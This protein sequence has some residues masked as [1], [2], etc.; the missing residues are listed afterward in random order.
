VK[1][2]MRI[3]KI[4]I[5]LMLL[6]AL[7]A[8]SFNVSAYNGTLIVNDGTS[9]VISDVDEN[10]SL[11]NV[12]IKE[13]KC[14]QTGQMVEISL[15]LEDG[16]KFEDSSIFFIFLKTTSSS[17]D[18]Y[19]QIIY[20]EVLIPE[21]TTGNP[22]T[23]MYVDDVITEDSFSGRGTNKITFEFKL[24]ES[25]E[26]IV[27][28]SAISTDISYKYADAAPDN[29][30]ADEYG[31]VP[32]LDVDAGDPY[33]TKT[34]ESLS[35]TGTID[36]GDASDY[37]WLW[38]IDESNIEFEGQNPSYT[39]KIPDIYTGILYVFD[40]EGNWGYDYFEINASSKSG[41]SS[42]GGGTN[43]E[44]G[45]ELVIV[46]AAIAIIAIALRRKRK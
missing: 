19:Y 44:P 36:D 37:T 10:I 13:L 46:V 40:D 23:I 9:D 38:K 12:D 32:N 45:F 43:E 11:P 28:L 17:P 15:Q 24:K 20:A 39:F 6:S 26:R 27:S 34:S 4:V 7:V 31:I 33:S 30:E 1:T 2:K 16:G 41:G 29:L 5:S 22:V 25:S 42:G 21:S 14:I 3:K 35:L 18:V 8:S